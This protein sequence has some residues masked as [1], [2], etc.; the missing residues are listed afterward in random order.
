[1]ESTPPHTRI[2]SLLRLGFGADDQIVWFLLWASPQFRPGVPNLLTNGRTTGGHL[3][4]WLLRSLM[5]A[6]GSAGV[7]RNDTSQSAK[8][9][10]WNSR[11]TYPRADDRIRAG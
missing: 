2:L 11:S 4:A 9:R 10:G 6:L 7:I 5:V 1:M 8:P 3:W